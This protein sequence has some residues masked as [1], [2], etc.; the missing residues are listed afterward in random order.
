MPAKIA[1]EIAASKREIARLEA[2]GSDG[3]ARTIA[4]HRAFIARMEKKYG[5]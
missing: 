4:H 2:S 5:A 3:A 1:A